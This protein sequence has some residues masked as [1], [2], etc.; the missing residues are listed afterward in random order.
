MAAIM[1][2][3]WLANDLKFELSL[4]TLYNFWCNAKYG[5]K[6]LMVSLVPKLNMQTSK[7]RSDKIIK[8][9]V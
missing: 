9:F 7:S 8:R 2:F 3:G 5:K 4:R 6:V 1:R